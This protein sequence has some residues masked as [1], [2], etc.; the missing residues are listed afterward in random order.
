MPVSDAPADVALTPING[1]S[2]TL[3]Q[4][5]TTFHLVL[6]ALDPFT[7]ESAWLLP[8]VARIFRVYDQADCRVAILVTCTAE[9][10]RQFLGP[11]AREFLTF[12]D[13]DRQAVKG[14]GLERLPA[15][16]HIR[17]DL[18]VAGAAE[19]WHPDEWRSVTDELSRA[20]SW[21]RPAI[22]SPR[23]PAAYEGTPALG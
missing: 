14:L 13:P 7:S 21:S 2:H 15:L 16:V 12:A 6:G 9:E 4:W 3:A 20:M 19:G 22:P 11:Y 10:A 1:S 5:L 18:S 8:T 23:D 17:Q